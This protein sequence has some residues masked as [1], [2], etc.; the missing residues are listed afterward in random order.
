ME[1]YCAKCKTTKELAEFVKNKYR[2][3][4]FENCCKRCWSIYYSN[5]SFKERH[6]EN[7]QRYRNKPE[8]L[9]QAKDHKLR[10]RYG[11]T[12]EEYYSLLEIQGGKCAICRSDTV[13]GPGRFRVD[14]DHKTCKVRGLLCFK[15]NTMLG[16]AK[17]D[18]NILIEAAHYLARKR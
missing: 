3:S 14:H 11:I 6:K 18:F 4:G 10:K 16:N 2:K 13:D 7:H 12:L 8:K 5:P 17:D 1:K 9:E 15:C